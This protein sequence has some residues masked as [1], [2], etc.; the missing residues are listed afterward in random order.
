MKPLG[1]PKTGIL[2]KNREFNKVYHA[3]KRVYGDNFVV[4][5]LPNQYAWSRLGVS[6][7]KKV[8]GAV[9]RNR[10][11]R[12]VREVFRLNQHI[13]PENSDVVIAIRPG[14]K[15]RSSNE[16]QEKVIAALAR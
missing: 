10:I 5:T 8:G 7:P 9:R 6:V 14:F 1:L 15:A 4:V 13:F 2:R 3:G 16:F 12:I 11:K